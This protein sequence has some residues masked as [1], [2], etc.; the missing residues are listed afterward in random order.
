[1]AVQL[2]STSLLILV[3]SSLAPARVPLLTSR[4]LLP[5]P[6]DAGWLSNVLISLL[7]GHASPE[8]ISPACGSFEW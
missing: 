8:T 6:G 1:M 2:P 4:S 5:F 7:R 3:A